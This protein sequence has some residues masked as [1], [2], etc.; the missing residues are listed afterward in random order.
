V[1]GRQG[2]KRD[3]GP[4]GNTVFLTNAA[5]AKPWRPFAEDDDRRRIEHGGLKA[6]K[7]PWRWKPPPQEAARA[8]RGPVLV[9]SRLC[10]LAT[11]SRR[12]GEPGEAG[13]EPIGWQ[14]G[15]RQR[16][17]QTRDRVILVA[18]DDYGILHSAESSL[19]WGV[20]RTDVPPGIGPR[21]PMLATYGRAAHG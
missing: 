20:N 11:A 13:A 5:V 19:V 16:L 6:R 9:P 2:P 12:Q 7:P 3:D 1:V 15:R 10:A 8:G 14:R 17:A 21:P 4:G 18:E